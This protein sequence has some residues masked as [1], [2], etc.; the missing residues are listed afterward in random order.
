M[1]V[2]VCVF[3]YVRVC[4]SLLS[5]TGSKLSLTLKHKTEVFS[6]TYTDMEPGVQLDI[7]D[8]QGITCESQSER[9]FF[10]RR[11]SISDMLKHAYD[12]RQIHIHAR[13]SS[14]FSVFAEG[15]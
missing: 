4:V 8:S 15:Y 11:M 3:V 9:G 7:H 1:C 12:I 5:V 2:C 13:T 10:F 6:D 14:T